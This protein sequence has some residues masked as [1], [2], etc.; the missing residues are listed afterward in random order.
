MTGA[1][2]FVIALLILPTVG[3]ELMP[4]TDEG[5]VTVDAE[6][7]VGTRIERDARRP[8]T[9]RGDDPAGSA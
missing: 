2:L 4:Q 6:L 9:A 7:P 3:F 5:E 1:A 8:R